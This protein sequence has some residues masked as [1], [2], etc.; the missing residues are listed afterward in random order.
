MELELSREY[1]RDW[2]G[3]WSMPGERKR[4]RRKDLFNNYH[5]FYLFILD[6]CKDD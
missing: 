3:L 2:I 1:L 6:F 4:R 5:H